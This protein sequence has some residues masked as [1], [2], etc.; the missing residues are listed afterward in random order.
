MT[1][2]NSAVPS[3]GGSR[4]EGVVA[5]VS[6]ETAILAFPATLARAANL[7][8]GTLIAIEGITPIIASVA[9]METP[10]GLTEPGQVEIVFAEVR[11]LGSLEAGIP[12][13]RVTC[14]SVGASARLLDEREAIE[15]REAALKEPLNLAAGERPLSLE[16]QHLMR[17][18]LVI[19]GQPLQTAPL[20][21]LIIRKLLLGSFPAR[22]IVLDPDDLFTDSFGGAAS[23]VDLSLGLAPIGLLN[24][25]EIAAVL[26]AVQEP[27]SEDERRLLRMAV[28]GQGGQLRSLI[29]ELDRIGSAS[30]DDTKPASS[31]SARLRRAREDDRLAL[32]L[33]EEADALDADMVVQNLFRLPDGRPPMTVCQLGNL[34]PELH[35]PAAKIIQRFAKTLAKTSGGRIPVLFAAHQVDRLMGEA[36]EPSAHFASLTTARTFASGQSG[37]ATHGAKAEGAGTEAI[38]LALRSLRAGEALLLDPMLPWPQAFTPQALPEGAQPGGSRQTGSEGEGDARALLAKVASAFAGGRG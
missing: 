26:G 2:A 22:L 24:A 31:L 32:F 10:A 3:Q 5:S 27:L 15:A 37:I 28:R 20:F 19:A 35:R 13:A 21:A 7:T 17:D 9:A 14:P 38:E 36:P 6:A 1:G 4:L 16:L 29:A 12:M 34:V 23:V 30:Q 33:S 8:I 18:G 25:D 11:L